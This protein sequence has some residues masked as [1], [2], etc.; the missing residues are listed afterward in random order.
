MSSKM[1]TQQRILDAAQSLFAESGFN[2]TS[3]RQITTKA[4]VNLASVNYHFGSKK[5][6]IQAVLQRYLQVLMPRLDHEFDRL[7][8]SQKPNDLTQILSVFVKPLLD[9]NQ[10]Q[11]RGTRT[12]LQ[13]LGRGYTD[14]QGHLRWFINQ[15]YGRTLDKFV[16]LVQQSCPHLP[17][18]EVFWRLHFSLGS[19]VFTMASSDALSEIAQADFNESV[20][21]EGV[22]RRLIPYLGA[23][24]AAPVYSQDLK[25]VA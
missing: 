12:F 24:I 6:L 2:D 22:I 18:S 13:L 20:D 10:L 9:L 21:I 7:L 5:E 23:A 4:E 1:H 3:L 19:I 14:V 8:A 15:H 11:R 25:T 17:Q 16:L